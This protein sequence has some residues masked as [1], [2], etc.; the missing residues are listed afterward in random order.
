MKRHLFSYAACPFLVIFLLLVVA[1]YQREAFNHFLDSHWFVLSLLCLILLSI[2]SAIIGI[3]SR[4]HN[5]LLQTRVKEVENHAK[6]L[7]DEI[8]KRQE[9]ES[10][11]QTLLET[12]PDL[13]WLKDP[14]GIFLS[15]NHKFERFLGASE[16]V[17]VGKTD[18]DFLPRELA[19]FFR[20]KDQA[21]MASDCPLVNE[22]QV[23]YAD[24]G[25]QET[26]ETIRTTLRD[27]NGRIVG[28]LGIARDIT[29]R[30]QAEKQAHYLSLHDPLT[31]LYNRRILE[32]RITEEL[33]RAERYQR[34]LSIFML[35]LDH[36]KLV[37]D[38]H[39]HQNG[40]I[41]LCHL[42]QLLESS[43]R[44]TDYVARYGGEEFI[45][46]LPETPLSEALELAERLC[47]KIAAQQ[48]PIDS[49]QTIQLTVSIGVSCFP[50]HHHTWKGLIK[51]ADLAMYSAK[52]AGRN[53]VKA[54]KDIPSS[55]ASPTKTG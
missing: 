23:T 40:D 33:N 27:K 12:I 10:Q 41:A 39:G 24:D 5:L 25:H 45:V 20:V 18:Y 29:C 28:V 21:A 26:L 42:A 37:N 43:I 55:P 22:E 51:S 19:D 30:K 16:L 52:T 46:V 15:C 50:E 44:K 31:G 9:S 3:R 38:T 4:T 34:C 8:S 36:F 11:L 32:G 7:K 53:Q 47:D 6:R 13:V 48:I 49:H 14:E 35:D 17:I 2:C 1:R 54:A